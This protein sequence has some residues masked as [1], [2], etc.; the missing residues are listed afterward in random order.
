MNDELSDK[1]FFLTPPHPCSYLEDRTARTLFLD[2]RETVNPTIYG[3]LTHA[4]FRRSGSHL[5]RPYCEG[6]GACVPVRVPVADF[7]WS[8]RFRRIRRT[9]EG[10]TATMREAIFSDRYYDLYAN[11]INARHADGDMH[12]PNVD[13]FRSFLLSSWSNSAFLVLEEHG[14]L[15][16]VAVTDRV[17]DGLSAI[18]TFFD[19]ALSKRSIGVLAVLAQIQHCVSLG[20]PYLYL[21]YWVRESAKMRYK[22]DYRPIELLV[23]NRWSRLT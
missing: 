4:G 21:G 11:Y 6:C 18:Y 20:I 7:R 13:Q 3:S 14:K 10:V 17:P 23:R 15:I 1:Q 9:N 19:P 8:R 2:P 12:P 5:Y 16:A 22:T